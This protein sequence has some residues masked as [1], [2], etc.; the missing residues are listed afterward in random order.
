[1]VGPYVTYYKNGQIW[2]KGTLKD[3]KKHGRYVVYNKDGTL[4][5]GERTGTFKNG[6]KVSS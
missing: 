1:M 5:T 6:V 4:N 2:A 3:G